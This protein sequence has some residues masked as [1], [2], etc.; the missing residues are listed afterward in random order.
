MPFPFIVVDQNQFRNPSAAAAIFDRCCRERLQ[1]LIPDGAGFEL[2]KG[3]DPY[4]TWVQTLTPIAAYSE[5]VVVGRKI[6]EICRDEFASGYPSTTLVDVSGTE[7]F[8]DLLRQLA[9][10]DESGIRNVIEGPVKR[11]KPASMDQW[12]NHDQIKSLIVTVRDSINSSLTFAMIKDLRKHNVDAMCAWL[13]S[14]TGVRFIFQ[15]L[16]SRGAT[17]ATAL[18]LAVTPSVLGFFVSGIAAMALYWIAFG[19]LD[20]VPP[21]AATNDIHDLEYAVLGALSATMSSNDKRLNAILQA[22]KGGFGRPQ[23]FV[24]ALDVGPERA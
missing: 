4:S 19:G 5:L 17:S 13:A 1:I 9:S 15:F 12:S 21:K 6:T 11:L 2:S 3:S 7:R 16:K 22:I 10:G 20:A 8:R 18:R 23:W 14:S 24:R